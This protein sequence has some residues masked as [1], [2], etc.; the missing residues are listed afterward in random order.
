[1]KKGYFYIAVTTIFFSLM[2]IMLKSMGNAFNPVQVT[3]TRFLIG[4][5]VLLPLA[6]RHL[7]KK[8]L[9]FTGG[10]IRRFA[11]LG[12]IGVAVS[13]TF[14]Q[15]AVV[16]TQASVVAVLFSSNSIFVMVFAFLLLGEPIYRR[17]LVSLGLDIVG[18]LFVINV[19]QM[20]LSLA[21]VI[22]TMLATVT[23]ALYGVGGKK[24]TEKF[25]GLVNTC[26]SFL[27]GSLEMIL[28]ALLTYIPG[29]AAA[30]NHAGLTMFSRIPL[31]SGY[32]LSVL[33]AFLF[34]CVG[35]T[36]IGYACYFQAMETVSV[37]TVSLVFFFKPV[38]API[39]ALLVLGDPMPIT[40]IV[41][42][43]FILAGS[44]VNILPPML[45]ARQKA[46]PLAASLDEEA[47]GVERIL[48]E[49]A[50]A[51]E[52]VLKEVNE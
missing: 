15:L 24:P 6:V 4:G 48:T 52:R 16:Y 14:Y 37:N 12:L 39:L 22:F 35:V 2:E 9:H 21:G 38:L 27:L 43:C 33:P 18:I 3:F 20:K 42:I 51:A 19:L 5:L 13:M 36:G 40:K 25:G 31:F 47:A 23:F 46:E 50:D 7:R 41:G 10:D 34:V 8:N 30:M 29:V 11:L 28:L 1:M 49:E 26:M 32:S 17:N 44:L 45:A